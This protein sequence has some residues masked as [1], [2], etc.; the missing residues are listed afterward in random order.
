M[1]RNSLSTPAL[2]NLKNPNKHE[3][4]LLKKQKLKQKKMDISKMIEDSRY[5]SSFTLNYKLILETLKM[6]FSKSGR[7]SPIINTFLDNFKEHMNRPDILSKIIK[8]QKL[9][10]LKNFKEK[11]LK[12]IEEE[13]E[14]FNKKYSDLLENFEV[15]R[16]DGFY[17]SEMIKF[18]EK[19]FKKF[20]SYVQMANKFVQEERVECKKLEMAEDEIEEIELDLFVDDLKVK[21][22]VKL[23]QDDVKNLKKKPKKGDEDQLCAIE[24]ID[25][26]PSK[27]DKGGEEGASQSPKQGN[28]LPKMREEIKNDG[29][30]MTSPS[31]Y[32]DS[33]NSGISKR[34]FFEPILVNPKNNG[35]ERIDLAVSDDIEVESSNNSGFLGKRSEINIPV[36]RSKKKRKKKKLNFL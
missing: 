28:L 9:I 26:E 29:S 1:I 27:E 32:I 6:D 8:N 19:K 21:E 3:R 34:K 33:R 10:F 24:V 16:K 14:E 23:N 12:K 11:K 5:N 31:L 22:L 2:M 7:V 4:L 15:M 18:I 25:C 36:I 13:N 20:H 30:L 35:K 17:L